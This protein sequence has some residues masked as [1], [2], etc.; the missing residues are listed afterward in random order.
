MMWFCNTFTA[1]G[2]WQALQQIEIVRSI[3]LEER[4]RSVS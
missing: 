3:I 2:M 1:R 4:K